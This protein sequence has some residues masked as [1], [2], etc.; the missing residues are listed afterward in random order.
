[1]RRETTE[2]ASASCHPKLTMYK[3][4]RYDDSHSN[5][6]T[7]CDYNN[8]LC[9]VLYSLKHFQKFNIKKLLD[10]VLL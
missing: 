5:F 8:C 4:R 10:N 6:K 9:Q 2:R 1:M 7:P 3:V